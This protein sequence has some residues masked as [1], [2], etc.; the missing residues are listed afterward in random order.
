MILKCYCIEDPDVG[1]VQ[2]MNLIMAGLL[3]H[4]KDAIHTYAVFREINLE[5]RSLY[6]QGNYAVIETIRSAT[7]TYR[8]YS[9][10]WKAKSTTFTSTLLMSTCSARSS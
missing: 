1:Y 5:V 6:L 2:G 8:A 7:G 3:F 10:I 4:L 9:S